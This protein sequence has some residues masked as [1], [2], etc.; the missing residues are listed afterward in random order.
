MPF[1]LKH[2]YLVGNLFHSKRPALQF[3]VVDP[4]T[5]VKAVVGAVVGDIQRGEEHKAVAIDALLDKPRGC[6]DLVYE[7]MV[8]TLK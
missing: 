3:L 6:K 8:L 2:P 4:E 1:P 7:I 5:A